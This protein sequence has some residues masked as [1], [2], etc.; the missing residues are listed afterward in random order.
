MKTKVFTVHHLIKESNANHHHTLFAGQGAS[1][2]VEIGAICAAGNAGHSEI[3][4]LKIHGML[5]KKPVKM[6]SILRMDAQVVLAGR[7]SLTVHIVA[8]DGITGD[9]IVDGYITYIVTDPAGHSIPHGITFIPETDEEKAA[10]TEAN[11][12]LSN[13]LKVN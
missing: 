4:C 7:S 9:F 8:S 5:F 12:L 2:M 10:N 6:G 13:N 1:W 3:V 11:R